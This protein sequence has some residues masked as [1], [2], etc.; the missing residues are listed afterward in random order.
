MDTIIA[1]L[2]SAFL[3]CCP[4]ISE[5]H[6]RQ[7]LSD[8]HHRQESLSLQRSLKEFDKGLE[9]QK[10][11]SPTR[12]VK[13]N[14]KDSIRKSNLIKKEIQALA[15]AD[16]LKRKVEAYNSL[17]TSVLDGFTSETPENRKTYETY[18]LNSMDK[19]SNKKRR[20]FSK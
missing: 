15:K 17:K 6:L 20:F 14:P 1:C 18:F 9:Q 4:F 10:L 2:Y 3:C 12:E 19:V 5:Q 13:I 7:V 11:L 16:V 8:R